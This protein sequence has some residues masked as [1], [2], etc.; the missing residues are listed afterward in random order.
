[1]KYQYE[2]KTKDIKLPIKKGDV[3]GKV[4][5]TGDGE[6]VTTVD[7]VSTESVKSLSFL[8]LLGRE[9]SSLVQG[10]FQIL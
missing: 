8:Q 10:E 3:L 5:V 1:M 4:V 2:V 9:L 6:E 7:L